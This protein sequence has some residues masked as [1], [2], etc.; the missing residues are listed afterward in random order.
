[1]D[2]NKVEVETQVGRYEFEVA[3]AP[4]VFEDV[5]EIMLLAASEHAIP[6][7]CRCQCGRFHL[8]GETHEERVAQVQR[9]WE[10]E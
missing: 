1:M 9:S 5:E 6:W 8:G 10:V 2:W 4:E 7:T 3:R